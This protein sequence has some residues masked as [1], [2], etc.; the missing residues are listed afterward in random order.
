M[1]TASLICRCAAKLHN[2][3]IDEAL[4]VGKD[5]EVEVFEGAPRSLGYL[6]RHP[7]A[8]DE[9]IVSYD[10]DDD[11]LDMPTGFSVRRKAIIDQIG[12]IGL[13]RPARNVIRN[14]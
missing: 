1:G 10:S 5:D 7:E 2:F 14:G 12:V 3:I 8:Q 13:S 11:M 9:N 6:P 4:V